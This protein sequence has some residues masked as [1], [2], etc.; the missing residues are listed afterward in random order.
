MQYKNL[1]LLVIDEEQRFGVTHK[2][3]IKTMKKDVDVLSLSAT[4]IPRTLH[5]SLIGIRDMSVLEEPPHDRRAIQTYVME[6]QNFLTF[7][8]IHD[9]II[10][11]KGYCR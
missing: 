6:N 1:G 5:M 7:F 8:Q 2:E 11:E 4:P 10:I 9:T 3:K